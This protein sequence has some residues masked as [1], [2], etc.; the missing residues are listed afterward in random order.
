MVIEGVLVMRS[1]AQKGVLVR[2]PVMIL[3]AIACTRSS[4]VPLASLRV[5]LIHMPTL[6][7]RIGQTTAV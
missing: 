5:A 2:V 4:L 3:R 6:Y 1:K 7:D